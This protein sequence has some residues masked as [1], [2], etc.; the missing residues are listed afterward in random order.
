MLSGIKQ[1]GKIILLKRASSCVYKHIRSV[2]LLNGSGQFLL[3]LVKGQ[4][5][6]CSVPAV[7]WHA[8]PRASFLG[9]VSA[10]KKYLELFCCIIDWGFRWGTTRCPCL[11]ERRVAAVRSWKD[12]KGKLL[13]P[14][15]AQVCPAPLYIAPA[16]SSCWEHPWCLWGGAWQRTGGSAGEEQRV[17][18]VL[19]CGPEPGRH[20]TRIRCLLQTWSVLLPHFI[21]C[22]GNYQHLPI[23][24]PLWASVTSNSF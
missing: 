19:D 12:K 17:P 15:T 21:P 11:M 8:L 2:K 14:H 4:I 9:W 16:N 20:L 23:F 7:V 6:I 10:Q 13:I 18:L 22:V 24:S 5:Y 1:R 3:L